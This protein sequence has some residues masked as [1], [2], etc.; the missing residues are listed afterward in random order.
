MFPIRPHRSTG[1]LATAS[2]AAAAILRARAADFSWA[3]AAADYLAVYDHLL[4]P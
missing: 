3:R 2:G 1:S 4:R